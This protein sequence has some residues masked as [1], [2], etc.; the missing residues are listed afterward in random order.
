MRGPRGI[1]FEFA[2]QATDVDAQI[3]GFAVI[4]GS[5]DAPQQCFVSK[6][7]AGMQRQLLD[8]PKLRRRKFD[9]RA[10]FTNTAHPI[11]YIALHAASDGKGVRLY[12][13]MI[14]AG[15]ENNG[16]FVAWDTAQVHFLPASQIAAQGVAAEL[17][18]RQIPVRT[19]LGPVRPL[20]NL[21]AAAVAVEVAPP[22]TDVM[23][24]NLPAYQ[25][26]VVSAVASGI[27]AVRDRLA[28]PR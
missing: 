5:P 19:L 2:A 17:A 20:N 27:L 8:E 16:P 15:G 7:L 10:I 11:V 28:V 14:P 26:N 22:G 21:I 23:D 9:Q 24:L 25:Q 12:T 13:A 18:R 6:N 1:V 3:F 4:F